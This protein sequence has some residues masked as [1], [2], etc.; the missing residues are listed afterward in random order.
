VHAFFVVVKALNLSKWWQA[1][2]S[3]D[4]QLCSDIQIKAYA[5]I[6]FS[7]KVSVMRISKF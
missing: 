2:D 4:N 5:D 3:L 1:I 7:L 6:A